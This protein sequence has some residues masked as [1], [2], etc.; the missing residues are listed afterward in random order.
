VEGVILSPPLSGREELVERLREGHMPLALIAPPLAGSCAVRVDD[1]AAAV[2]ATRHLLELGHRR[3]GFI[4]GH[5]DHAAAAARQRGYERA[6]REAGIEPEPR[7]AEPG[8]FTFESGRRA[9]FR[10]LGGRRRPT[11]ILASNDDMAAGAISAAH[12]SGLELPRELSVAGFDDSPLAAMLWPPLTTMRQP[13]AEMAGFA[14]SLLLDH[15]RGIA[16]AAPAAGVPGYQLVRRASTC[17][18]S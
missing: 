6:L 12:A 16:A 11:A 8:E 2:A 1:E 13:I 7:L 14:T 17:A 10:L 5:P 15:L 9:A 18:P 3:I 4:A